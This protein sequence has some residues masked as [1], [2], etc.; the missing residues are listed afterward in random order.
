MTANNFSSNGSVTR[1]SLLKA[2]AIA[3]A[4]VVAKLDT[5]VGADGVTLKFG[6]KSAAV[7]LLAGKQ[8]ELLRD[9]SVFAIG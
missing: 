3:A 1:R 2:G 6:S 7:R 8:L 9:D 4:G 5:A